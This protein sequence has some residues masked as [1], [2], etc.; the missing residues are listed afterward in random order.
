MWPRR[1]N[2]ATVILI[3]DIFHAGCLAGGDTNPT[4]E[5]INVDVA[6]VNAILGAAGSKFTFVAA[7]ANDNI[8]TATTLDVINASY[9]VNAGTG[10][11][12]SI[13]LEASRDG[14]LAP[15]GNP[16]TLTNGPAATLTQTGNGSDASTGFNDGRNALFGTQFA[17]PTSTFVAGN[18]L[19]TP[20]LGGVSTCND[21][22]QLGGIVEPTPF[23]LSNK[24]VITSPA[25]NQGATYLVTDASTK[26]ASPVTVPEP[27]SLLLFGVGLAGLGF[28]RRRKN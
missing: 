9:Q 12:G 16:K 15:V 5:D 4:L 1:L 3:C 6:L 22:T 20:V 23:S 21:L 25:G 17:T 24:Q 11:A 18:A 13:S 10:G 7:G 28:V 27:A 19:C 2:G 8:L 26:F 14:W